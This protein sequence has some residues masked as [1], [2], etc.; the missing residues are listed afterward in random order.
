[1]VVLLGGVEKP[2]GVTWERGMTVRS[3]IAKAGG[4]ATLAVNT[5]VRLERQ[6]QSARTLDLSKPGIDAPVQEGDRIIV[7]M[8]ENRLYVTVSGAVNKGGFIEHKSGMTLTQ[9]IDAGGGFR[10]D[11]DPG[12]VRLTRNGQNKATSYVIAD[13]KAGRATDPVLSPGDKVMVDAK[14]TRKTGLPRPVA[15][16]VLL[17]I[18]I[19]R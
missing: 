13:I 15:L 6:S 17:Y 3:A 14:S 19:G 16:L 12:K 4:F 5:S 1:M 10:A 2:G 9:A 11:A 8:R 18:L 7:A